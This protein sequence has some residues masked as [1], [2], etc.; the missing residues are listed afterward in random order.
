[1]NF[2]IRLS[3]ANMKN[4]NNSI[5][6]VNLNLKSVNSD[7]KANQDSTV[8][9]LNSNSKSDANTSHQYQ[10][11]IGGSNF[12]VIAGP[13]SIESS[14]QFFSTAAHIQSHGAQFLRGGIYKMRTKKDSFQGLGAKAFDLVSQ[15]RQNFRMPFV[16]EVTDPRQIADMYPLVDM[17]QVGSRN[18]YNYELLKDLGKQD[19]PVLLKRGFSATVD[20]WLNAAEYITENN[21][22]VILCERGVRG[23][24]N[25][26]RNMLDL[27][28]VAYIKKFTNYPVIVD[29]SHGTG[30][31]ELIKPMALAAA[32]AGADGIMLEV[33]PNP[34]QALS[35]AFQ[36]LSFEAYSDIM[37]DL[38]KIL[39]A[40]DKKLNF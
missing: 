22:N 6:T 1:M 25:K 7:S 30:V 15:A 3:R 39:L 32:A 2:G 24:D 29:P 27:A 17:F 11:Q 9:I 26:T 8:N 37:K 23:F 36:A 33:H 4:K 21:P 5:V 18:M 14:E 10:W 12:S 34:D 40:M 13:C 16:A 20:E 31:R 19:K 35:D 28:S 38:N